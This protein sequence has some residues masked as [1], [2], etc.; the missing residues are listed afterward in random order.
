MVYRIDLDDGQRDVLPQLYLLFNGRL[1]RQPEITARHEPFQIVAEVD[2][3]ATVLE[4]NNLSVQLHTDRIIFGDLEPWI[5]LSLLQAQRDPLVVGIDVEDHDFNLVG[6]RHHLGGM[7]HTLRPRHVRDMNESVDTR[8]NFYERTKGSQ[9]SH[10][11]RDPCPNGILHREHHPGI[12]LGLLHTEGDLL[13]LRI[14]LEHDGFD[15]LANRNDGRRVT[16]GPRPTHLAD[17]YEPLDARLQL[18][19]G[20]VIRNRDDLAL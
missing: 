2:R 13:F 7:L 1:F 3:H 4:P 20:A 14:H 12:L 10:L 5:F 19:K 8:L 17:V 18:D 9:V 11:A 6:F 15:G 16:Y